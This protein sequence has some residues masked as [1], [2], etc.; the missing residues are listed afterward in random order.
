MSNCEHFEK[1]SSAAFQL[2]GV[3]RQKVKRPKNLIPPTPPPPHTHTP[4][5]TNKAAFPDTLF[6]FRRIT[7]ALTIQKFK[8]IERNFKLKIDYIT[9]EQHM[10]LR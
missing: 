3:Y 8:S 5:L 1:N 10:D 6:K 9:L 4:A 2:E 7:T